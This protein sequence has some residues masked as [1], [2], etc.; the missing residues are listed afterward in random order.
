LSAGLLAAAGRYQLDSEVLDYVKAKASVAAE[1]ENEK[2]YKKKDEYDVLREKV[3]HI[4]SL[5]L[6]AEKW[7]QGQLQI[8][9]RWFKRPNDPK[10]PAKKQECLT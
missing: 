3:L 7:T 1:K 8:M 4:R 9:L 2:Y 6:P 10:M 5:N